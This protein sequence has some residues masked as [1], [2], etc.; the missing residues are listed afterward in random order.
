MVRVLSLISWT[1]CCKR[2]MA[3]RTLVR[4][5][6]FPPPVTAESV[7]THRRTTWT[8]PCRPTISSFLTKYIFILIILTSRERSPA[9]PPATRSRISPLIWV[10][11]PSSR[12]IRRLDRLSKLSE[13][14]AAVEAVKTVVRIKG[15]LWSSWKTG[16]HWQTTVLPRCSTTLFCLY[17]R[18]EVTKKAVNWVVLCLSLLLWLKEHVT[19]SSRVEHNSMIRCCAARLILE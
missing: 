4:P 5:C 16:S 10:R 18:S 7:T 9:H 15:T 12:T 1:P 3:C 6:G 13:F 8:A 19:S 17:C 14:K 11:I 2:Q